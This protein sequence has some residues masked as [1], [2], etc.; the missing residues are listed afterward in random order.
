M[1][2]HLFH[3]S[4]AVLFFI[5]PVLPA[6]G[7]VPPGFTLKDDCIVPGYRIGPVHAEC[8][9][10]ELGMIYGERKLL[11]ISINAGEGFFMPGTVVKG[12]SD[13]EIQV[14]WLDEALDTPVEIS[15][16]GSDLRTQDGI[17]IGTTLVELEEIIGPFE[18][19]GFAWDYEGT[20]F[21]D[22]TSLE[23]YD[24]NLYIRLKPDPV[25]TESYGDAYS[26]LMGDRDYS[27][28][29]PD[30]RLLNPEIYEITLIFRDQIP[31][32]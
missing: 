4:F 17:G 23:E 28:T 26:S 8:T 5:L 16:V 27:S 14:I 13:V 10:E 1:R 32:E 29:D 12:G 25:S 22:G 11:D 3:I 19:T 7:D 9:R 24:G 2:F 18:M 31:A 6:G 20:I 21:L 15:A 30:M